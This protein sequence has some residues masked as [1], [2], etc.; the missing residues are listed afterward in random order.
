PWTDIRVRQAFSHIVDRDAM[1]SQIW[2]SQANP[3]PS[4]LAPGFPASNVEAL[5]DI[6]AF[7]PDKAKQL[8]S[9]AG[10]PDGK[11]F[12]KLT[13]TQRGGAATYEIATIQAYAAMVK[14]YLNIDTE[15]QEVDRDTFYAN[16]KTIDFGFVSYGMDYFD[17][18]NMLG[19]WVT[20]GRHPWT[21]A[22]YDKQV[23]AASVFG[24]AA[25]E[26]TKMFQAAE[27]ILV[28]DVPAAFTFFITPNQL[29]KSYLTGP[30]FQ[31]DH[32][33]IKAVHWPGY[34]TASTVPE[35]LWLAADA[36]EG[37]S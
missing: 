12:K 18:S 35:E 29:A 31:P 20:G 1:K 34:G 15:I 16:M 30:A 26:R 37:R 10:F 5:K 17:A 23:K 4:F 19:I 9:D 21:N 8:L 11:G 6:Q 27:K 33:G 13:I 24:G 25:D 36:P 22:E 3:A 32:N 28:T 14:Q 7:D 2:T